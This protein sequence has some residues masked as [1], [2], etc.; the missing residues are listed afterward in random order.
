[1]FL[2]ALVKGHIIQRKNS[3]TIKYKIPK[4]VLIALLFIQEYVEQAFIHRETRF[5]YSIP[6]RE[7]AIS[8]FLYNLVNQ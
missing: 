1:M 3:C 7:K 6:T 4:D 2:P 5:I 8:I